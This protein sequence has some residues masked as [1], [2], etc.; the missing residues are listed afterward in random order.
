MAEDPL[1]F[2]PLE[3]RG[4]TL[5]NRIVVG[6][7]ATYM[8]VAGMV[9]DWH[10]AH[11]SRFAGGGAALVFLEAAAISRQARMIQGA[12]GIW[13]DEQ[14]GALRRMTEFLHQQGVAAGLQLAYCGGAM[15]NHRPWDETD[16]GDDPLVANARLW[17]MDS[18][19]V[20]VPADPLAHEFARE[21]LDELLD[22]FEQ[23]TRRAAE[24]GFDVLEI[25]GGRGSILHAFLSPT[26]NRRGDEYGGTLE[27]RIG[28]PLDVV[29]SVRAAWPEERPLFY[30]MAPVDSSRVG[31]RL[32]DTVSFAD[33]LLR[34]GV[35]VVDLASGATPL[36]DDT[37]VLSD[38]VQAGTARALRGDA[39]VLAMVGGGLEGHVSA[40]D[41]LSGGVGDLVALV[42]ATVWNPNWPLHAADVLGI[43]PEKAAWQPPYGWALRAPASEKL[44]E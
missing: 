43:D 24:A 31:W 19:V 14:V 17:D 23:A 41:A 39:G 34:A 25:H 42:R 5:A 10:L 20:E 36:A 22:L 16:D 8:A 40:E 35:D 4:L 33:R 21:T 29:D 44:Q 28:F 13:Q 32:A 3:I 1:L 6:P 2:A 37:G 18:T 30:R 11:L 27:T 9:G 26:D 7:M 12:V 38:G 15:L